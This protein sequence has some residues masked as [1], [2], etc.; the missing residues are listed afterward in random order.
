MTEENASPATESSASTEA[1]GVAVE[2]TP[3]AEQVSQTSEPAKTE[4]AI[5]QSYTPNF[6]F[7]AYDKVHQFPEWIR[8]TIKDKT[9]EDQLRDVF[10]R[11]HGFDVLKGKYEKTKESVAKYGEVEKKYAEQTTSLRNLL[12]LRDTDLG[13]F[14]QAVGLSDE[15]ILQ[16]YN[17]VM[18][19]KQDPEFAAQYNASLE[20]RR[21]KLQATQ[22][23][24]SLKAQMEQLQEER[25]QIQLERHVSVFEQTYTKPDVQS[26]ASIFDSKAGREGAFKE[27]AIELGN[28]IY[29][30]E[31]RY[32]PPQEV[33]NILMQKYGA[34]VGSGIEQTNQV[35]V[36]PAQQAARV[37]ATIPNV[38]S[39]AGVSVTKPRF[40]SIEDI[41]KHY[42]KT[43]GE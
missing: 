20:A 22:E 8:P 37:S 42:N 24:E 23:Q 12:A 15:M 33:F 18:R 32:A 6:E 14:I 26:F 3:T 27:E 11:A 19:A 9:H 21:Q 39:G 17:N 34:F 25:N 35:S 30:K 43:Y 5:Q 29:M 40:K 16:H 10:S 4:G 7:K 1:Q 38:G 28:I 2:S 13:Q 36:A 31:Q 41:K